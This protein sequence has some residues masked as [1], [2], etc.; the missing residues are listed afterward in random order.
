MFYNAYDTIKKRFNGGIYNLMK[1]NFKAEGFTIVETMIVLA[2]AGLILLIV[3]LAVPALQ[4]SSVNT[5]IKSDASAIAAAITDY[6]SNNGGAVPSTAA[7]Y[8]Q[9]GSQLT[10]SGSSS[11]IKSV[12]KIQS[13]DSIYASTAKFTP[14]TPSG[15]SSI[16][17]ST[18]AAGNDYIEIDLGYSCDGNSQ[19]TRIVSIFY[20]VQTSSGFQFSSNNCV[21]A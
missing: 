1:K 4:R 5:N 3:L 21:Q 2:I 12:A 20:P 14:G 8:T 19:S 15:G 16:S 9:N 18:S 10:V 11:D 6:E 17:G 13:A 7:F